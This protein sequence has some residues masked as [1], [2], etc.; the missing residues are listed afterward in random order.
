MK[1]I[2]L[3]LMMFLMVLTLSSC[4]DT[5][6]FE[7]GV[8]VTIPD[9][10][11]KHLVYA[12][13]LPVFHFEYDGV[14]NVA[15]FSTK[16]KYLFAKNDFYEF[17]DAFSKNI[18]KFEGSSIN[19]K[20]TD[21]TNDEGFARFGSVELPLDAPQQYSKEIMCVG[22]DKTGTRFS[23]F[24]RTFVSGG[25]RYF[26]T[27]YTTNVT[28]TM[29]VPIYVDRDNGENKLYLLNLPYDT[30][31]EVSG[32]LELDALLK[33]DEYANEFYYQF[34]YPAYLTENKVEGIKDWYER[35]CE[36]YEENG[37]FYFIYLGNKFE[38][39][40]DVKVKETIGF[41]IKLVK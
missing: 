11:V 15:E 21:Q 13:E 2:V 34:E 32:N 4:D 22:W 7:N 6:S 9:E 38:V 18:K 19:T 26:T 3:V 41:Q 5:I 1:K 30:K 29:E 35:Y 16:C 24:Y 40:F 12:G 39:L 10:I 28:I 17:S 20:V 25:K 14:V 36:G 31:Y 8:D 33:K 37:S 23:F 27:P